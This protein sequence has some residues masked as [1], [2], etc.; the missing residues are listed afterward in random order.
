MNGPTSPSNAQGTAAFATSTKRGTNAKQD[1]AAI[2]AAQA[3]AAHQQNQK[4]PLLTPDE[5]AFEA[6]ELKEQSIKQLLLGSI[7]G[8]ISTHD[9]DLETVEAATCLPLSS[10]IIDEVEQVLEHRDMDAEPQADTDK[11]KRK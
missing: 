10:L 2:A 9:R 5:V 11:K 4:N 3:A 6:R 8:M 1:A 7:M